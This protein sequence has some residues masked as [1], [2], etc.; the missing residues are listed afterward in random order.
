MV[1]VE[2]RHIAEGMGSKSLSLPTFRGTAVKLFYFYLDNNQDD[3][4]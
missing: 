4:I 3:N 1:N 2:M